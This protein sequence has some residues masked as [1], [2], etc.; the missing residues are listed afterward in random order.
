MFKFDPHTTS[1]SQYK[2]TKN[3]RKQDHNNTYHGGPYL[4]DQTSLLIS[5]RYEQAS[6]ASHN[7]YNSKYDSDSLSLSP[8]DDN[9]N[10]CDKS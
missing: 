6:G 7:T 2:R 10:K 9:I 1:S 5:V 8:S 4:H 3:K